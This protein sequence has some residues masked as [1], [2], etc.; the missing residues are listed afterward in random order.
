[1]RRSYI[2]TGLVSL[3]IGAL[4]CG[5]FAELSR[6][7]ISGSLVGFNSATGMVTIRTANG[8]ILRGHMNKGARY[9][10][11]ER[12]V[13][14]GSFT[15]GMRVA[16][17]VEGALNESPLQCDMLMDWMS[18]EK[19][20]A[21]V[22][23]APYQTPMGS[24]PTTSG[25]AGKSPDQKETDLTKDPEKDLM[26]L[27]AGG[28]PYSKENKQ[29]GEKANGSMPNG[30]YDNSTMPNDAVWHEPGRA[31]SHA[32]VSARPATGSDDSGNGRRKSDGPGWRLQ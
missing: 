4:S 32:A 22:A 14:P 7:T 27:A 26:M 20:V 18:S 1:M 5:A 11:G 25:V 30:Y 12:S 16:I 28:K 10:L 23:E 2:R 13:G 24:Y 21:K 3:A 29:L 17:R 15:K 31:D 19:Y 6:P 9:K 8:K